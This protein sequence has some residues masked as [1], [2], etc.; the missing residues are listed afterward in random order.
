MVDTWKV[1]KSQQINSYKVFST[2]KDVSQSELTGEEH[3]F[4]VIQSPDW[5][6][7]IPVTDHGDVVLIRQFR[8]GTQEITLEIPGGMVDEGEDPL[9]TAK[10]ELAEETGYTSGDWLKLGTVHPNPAIMENECHIF[11]AR[12]SVKSAEPHFDGTED[13][14]TLLTPER[15]IKKLITDGDITHSLV[16]SA[17]NLYF[18]KFRI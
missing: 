9:D 11:L 7:V 8:H 5:I 12:N 14:E 16:L 17:F 18:L 1:K 4:Y 3:E 13:I 10:R 6:N 15:E 2:R